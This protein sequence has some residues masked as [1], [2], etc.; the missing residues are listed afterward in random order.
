MNE[1][2]EWA[3]L[4]DAWGASRPAA[5]MP[6]VGL[7]I[8]RARRER[9]LTVLVLAGEWAMLAV[10]AAA[11]VTRWPHAATNGVETLWLGFQTLL[12]GVI[13]VVFTW[14]R[15]A[16]LREPTGTS[17]RDWL[18]L[19]RRR[20]QLGLRLARFTRWT[21]VALLPAPLIV[22]A[23]AR[24]TQG[25]I[26]GLVVTA[27][28][29]VGGWVWAQ[30]KRARMNADIAEVDALAQEWLDESPGPAGEVAIA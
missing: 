9:R 6:D 22:V 21:T 26:T 18:A 4:Q 10:A 11:I 15:L 2:D 23:T 27:L 3:S 20:A 1:Q 12:M 14:T 30:R 13:M 24:S 28:V 25:G 8:A 17:L 5:T 29:L 16:A 7:M 19:R